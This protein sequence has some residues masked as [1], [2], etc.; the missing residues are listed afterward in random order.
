MKAV[1]PTRI[2]VTYLDDPRVG[3]SLTFTDSGIRFRIVEVKDD[4]TAICER[5]RSTEKVID[6]VLPGPWS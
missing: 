6:D 1:E 3:D 4:G 2:E 5:V